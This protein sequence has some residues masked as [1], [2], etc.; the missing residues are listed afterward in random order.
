VLSVRVC[1]L[2]DIEVRLQRPVRITAGMVR[3]KLVYI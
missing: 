2:T 1:A 3:F